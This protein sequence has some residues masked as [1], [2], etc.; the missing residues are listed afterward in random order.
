MPST[1]DKAAH[2]DGPAVEPAVD[3]VSTQVDAENGKKV[4]V[5]LSHP[6]DKSYAPR[7]GLPDKNHGTGDKV[8]VTESVADALRASGFVPAKK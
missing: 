6:I 7:L 2:P 5:V 4:E 1:G 8:K 3:G